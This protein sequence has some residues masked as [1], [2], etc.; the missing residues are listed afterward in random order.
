[1]TLKANLFLMA[2]AWLN[3]ASLTEELLEEIMKKLTLFDPLASAEELNN[4]RKKL[5]SQIGVRG[6]KGVGLKDTDQEPWLD[7]RKLQ[8]TSWDYWNAYKTW[9][10][11]GGF[12]SDVLRVLDEDTDAILSLCGDPL[13]P[14][15]WSIKG[16]VMG[17][18][19]S[20][21]TANYTGLINK[22]ADAGYKVIIL[23]TGTI[24]AL[25]AQTQSRLDEGFAGQDSQKRLQKEE[26]VIGV[27]HLKQRKPAV[28]TSV[29]KDFLKANLSAFGGV[30]LKT[31]AAQEPVLLVL[32]KNKA[33]MTSLLAYLSSQIDA[34][35]NQIDLPLFLIDDE[36]DN[37][38]VNVRTEDNPATINKLI[39]DIKGIFNRS[40]YCGYTATPFAN[41]F[42]D[43]DS[44][45]DLFPENF[46]YTLHSP[47]SYLGAASIFLEDGEHNDQLVSIDDAEEMFPE[48]HNKNLP[49][50]EIPDSM[51]EAIRSFFISCCIRDIRDEVLKHRSMLINVSRFTDV[52][53]SLAKVV[54]AYVYDLIDEVRQYLTLDSAWK[55]HE[56]LA[57]LYETFETHYTGLGVTWD[58]IRKQLYQSVFSIKTVTVNQKSQD[59][60]RLNY[61]QYKNTPVGRRVIAIGGMTLSRG[62]TLE[63]LSTSYFYRNSKAYDTLLQMGRWFGYRSGYADLCRIWMTEE[64]QDWYSHLAEVVDELRQDIRLMHVGNRRPKDFGMRVMSH[65]ETL[66]VTARNKMKTSKEVVV[67]ISFS[68]FKAETPYILKSLEVQKKNLEKTIAFIN[69][70][71][72]PKDHKGRRLWSVSKEAVANYLSSIEI[73]NLNT[74]FVPSAGDQEHPLIK[75]IRDSNSGKMQSWDIALPQGGEPANEGIRFLDK[76]DIAQPFKPRGRQFEKVSDKA[77]YLKVNK[78]RVGDIEDET[79]G[80]DEELLSR[81]KSDW[82]N[83][84]TNSTK[85]AVS[86]RAY[87]EKRERPL[88]T[89]SLITPLGPR[90]SSG[91]DTNGKSAKKTRKETMDP[92]KVGDG[93]FVAIALSFPNMSDS[94]NENP[95]EFVTYRLNKVALQEL[96]LIEVDGDDDDDALD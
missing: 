76:N 60:E 47:T 29:D 6:F 13:R 91:A 67:Q 23:L 40:T 45:R 69:T 62:L 75:F 46:V 1:M 41:V 49:V 37:A 22:A 85:K 56:P 14:G 28:L 93:P 95:T 16:L 83:S 71:G 79:I 87:I 36:A 90:Q 82:Q 64:V 94:I 63:G 32:K 61:Q 88:L 73:C 2:I 4:V 52:Q 89:I 43:P 5:E 55:R 80:M 31:L 18:V 25:R 20:G 7:Q 70:L 54:G 66:L 30:A 34:E 10:R 72:K 96:G 65:P 24:E 53:A 77:N 59:T 58:E 21:K 74:A 44:D 33:V 42:I 38:S 68:K 51:K 19:Q 8:H 84:D 86:G 57:N 78:G 35:N 92:K 27:G 15:P 48:K 11:G 39:G 81:V 50:T 3:E 26:S 12:S 17:D 9:I